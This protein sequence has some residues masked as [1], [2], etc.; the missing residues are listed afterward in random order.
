MWAPLHRGPEGRG[1]WDALVG[2][3]SP[4]S[5]LPAGGSSSS[6]PPGHTDAA[7]VPGRHSSP[8]SPAPDTAVPTPPLL[9]L[10]LPGGGPGQPVLEVRFPSTAPPPQPALRNRKPRVGPLGAQVLLCL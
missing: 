5:C 6:H 7:S 8:F 10:A 9:R 2:T 4:W 1:Q 3:A